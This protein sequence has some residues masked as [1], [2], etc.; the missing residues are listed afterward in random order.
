MTQFLKP[1]A[2]MFRGQKFEV[3]LGD[4]DESGQA[5]GG[6]AALPGA[7][8][9]DVLERKPA[10]AK[11]PTAPTL[12]SKTGFPDHH[13]PRK[14]SRFKQRQ[15]EKPGVPVESRPSLSEQPTP[16]NG[17]TKQPEPRGEA[18]TFEEEEKARIDRENNERLAEM[19]PAEI[20]QER[21]ELMD[22]LSPEMIQLLL[23]RSNINSGGAETDLSR[24][25]ERPPGSILK[26]PEAREGK[27]EKKVTIAA[28][29]LDKP[30]READDVSPPPS[31]DEGTEPTETQPAEGDSVHFPRP[32]QPPPLDPDSSTFLQ[33][34]HTKYFP[35]LPSDPDKL[36]WMQQP[37]PNAK[38]NTYDPSASGLEPK[39]IRFSFK[40]ALIPPSSAAEIPVTAG[41]HHHGEAP[42]AAGYTIAELSHL[43]RSS[44]APQRCIAFQ[45][46]GRILYRLGLGEFGDAGERSD[47]VGAEE[48]FGALARGLWREMGREKITEMLVRESEGRGVDGG[49]HVSA[50]AYATEAVWLWQRG[51]GRR[52]AGE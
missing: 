2:N 40:G 20:E 12:K 3:D 13:G 35:S 43:V 39:D 26:Q 51:G 22:N 27:T 47:V 34:L 5:Q 15:N 1:D 16:T 21:R 24:H 8:V 44:Y 11:P 52:L 28:E 32:P 42:E 31:D 41:L 38:T 7:F 14:E 49:R 45:T 18:R 25:V 33:D 50:K 9:N 17:S 4:D 48:G 36:E 19:S 10:A 30:N 37:T 23:S 46:L 6:N 29:D